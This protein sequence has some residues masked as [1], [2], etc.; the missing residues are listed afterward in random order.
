VRQP[1]QECEQ[2]IEERAFFRRGGDDDAPPFGGIEC[3]DD[4][5]RAVLRDLVVA[6]LVAVRGLLPLGK[7]QQH[8]GGG[9]T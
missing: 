2:A 6:Q 3:S 5:L 7:V 9:A 1:P 8:A 4:L